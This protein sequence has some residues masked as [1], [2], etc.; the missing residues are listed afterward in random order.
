VYCTSKR[1]VGVDPTPTN[2]GIA[3]YVGQRLH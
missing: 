1:V 3:T 2:R